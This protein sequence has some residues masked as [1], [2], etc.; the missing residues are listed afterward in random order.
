VGALQRLLIVAGGLGGFAQRAA[1]Q[2]SFCEGELVSLYAEHPSKWF[3]YGA[4]SIGE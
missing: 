2:A 1:A 4:S 3:Q